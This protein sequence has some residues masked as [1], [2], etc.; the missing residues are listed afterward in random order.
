LQKA[1]NIAND[2]KQWKNI[3][4]LREDVAMPRPSR[5]TRLGNSWWWM[6]WS[7]ASVIGKRDSLTSTAF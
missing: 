1:I 2:R 7:Y 5:S 3:F 6:I 4:R